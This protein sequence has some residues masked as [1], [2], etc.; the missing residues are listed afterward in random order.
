[1]KKQQNLKSIINSTMFISKS[2]SL[3]R[4]VVFDKSVTLVFGVLE[5]LPQ[6]CAA[7]RGSYYNFLSTF[8]Q[9]R[10]PVVL[11]NEMTRYELY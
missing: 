3:K 2:C 5:A 6:C 11:S 8:Q 1:M 9:L 10:Q 7:N 4:S